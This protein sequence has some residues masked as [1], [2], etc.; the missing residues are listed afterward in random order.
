MKIT[1]ITVVISILIISAVIAGLIHLIKTIVR[2][3]VDSK[4]VNTREK[5]EL[6]RMHIEDM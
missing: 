1:F 2:T 3:C 6:L 5:E 4:K